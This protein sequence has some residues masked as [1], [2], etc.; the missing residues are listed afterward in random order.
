MHNIIG[1]SVCN[2]CTEN[3]YTGETSNLHNMLKRTT[4]AFF[5]LTSVQTL[6]AQNLLKTYSHEPGFGASILYLYDD[7][8]F[9]YVRGNCT[10]TKTSIG[11][12]RWVRDSVILKPYA[13]NDIVTIEDVRYC[14]GEL[15]RRDF[16]IDVICPSGD[17]TKIE[18]LMT[19]V[20]DADA[21]VKSKD[22][23]FLYGKGIM[24]LDTNTFTRVKPYCQDVG[25]CLTDFEFGNGSKHRLV[26]PPN[27]YRVEILTSIPF[28]ALRQ[29][30]HRLDF[31]PIKSDKLRFEDAV[32]YIEP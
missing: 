21:W 29:P 26:I 23:Q 30:R 8:T 11:S 7:S 28:G 27:V 18:W 2:F 1:L 32:F 19:T 25:I 9:A 12:V 16:E 15:C 13:A 10:R 22:S 20:E 17:T 24:K 14:T 31:Q 3:S 6:F 5:V 4:L